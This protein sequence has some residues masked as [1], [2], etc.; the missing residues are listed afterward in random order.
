[1]T[2][3]NSSNGSFVS[4]NKSIYDV[5]LIGSPNGGLASATTMSN[6]QS[7]SAN[8]VYLNAA[9]PQRMNDALNR[10]KVS[11]HQNVYEADFEYGT[12]PLRW[13]SFTYNTGVAGA[14]S[15]IVHRPDL[16]GTQMIIGNTAGDTTIRQSRPYHRYQPGKTM[17]MATAVWV[18]GA[19]TGQVQRIGFFDDGNGVFFEQRSPIPGTTAGTNNNTGMGVVVR[20]DVGGLPTDTRVELSDWNGDKN[21]INQ[22]N[23]NNIQM[24][25]VEYTWYGAG[26]ARFGTFLD[27][28]PYILHQ[29][30]FGNKNTVYPWA[31]TGNLPVRYEQ[32]NL[33]NI[34]GA[35]ANNSMYHWGVSVIVEGGRDAQRGF[36]YSYGMS[37]QTPRRTIPQNS[38]RY[39]VMT[40]RGRPMGTQ[41]Y[42]SPG[43]GITPNSAIV[44]GNSSVITVTGTPWTTNQWQGR[45]VYFSNSSGATATARIISSN[46]TSLVFQDNVL[47]SANTS[48]VPTALTGA[49]N[50][51]IIGIPNRGQLLPQTLLVSSDALCTIELVAGSQVNSPVTLANSSFQTVASLGSTYSF[52][53]RDVSANSTIGGEVVMA[54]TSPSGGSG[55]QQI[56]LTNLFPLYN[57]IRGSSP[58]TL[59]VA[60]TTPAGQSANV[61]AH[62]IAQEAMS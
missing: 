50:S 52:A 61:G 1:M 40:I 24:L 17:Y 29:M 7:L 21:I 62:I 59:T 26:V 34:P 33:T 18:A 4:T 23:W 2:Q 45:C 46:A 53:T 38:V 5:V 20:S 19:T 31:R 51:Y 39:P 58:D 15:T 30:A 8:T 44:S 9:P 22:L 37:P 47:G 25:W 27:G 36:T 54:F 35:G 28:Q 3:F 6:G 57:N 49:G 43:Q 14:N 32:R 56:D 48:G 16:G 42:A 13:E 60:I 12:Q 11:V 41:E 55:L 10:M